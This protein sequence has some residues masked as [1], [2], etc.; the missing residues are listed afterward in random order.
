[1]K[2]EDSIGYA[3]RNLKE[4]RNESP[5]A[6]TTQPEIHLLNINEVRVI[7]NESL[8]DYAAQVK[9]TPGHNMSFDYALQRM[10][11][12]KQF[13]MSRQRKLEAQMRLNKQFY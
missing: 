2:F 5:K 1:L 11:T 6:I 8:D 13:R 7:A 9:I 4:S 10:H 3:R 12:A